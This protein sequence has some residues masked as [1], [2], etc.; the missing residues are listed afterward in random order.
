MF[1]ESPRFPENISRGSSGGPRWSTEIVVSRGGYEQRNARWGNA[2]HEYDVAYGIKDIEHLEALKVHF[3][4]MRGSQHA[5]R[6]KD[7]A[8]YKSVPVEQIPSDADQQIG[9]G[10]VGG[11]TEF[12]LVKYYDL[13]GGNFYIRPINKPVDGTVLVAVAGAPIASPVVDTTTGIVTITPAPAPGEVVTAG[14][15]FDVP[16][17]FAADSLITALEVYNQAATSCNL[18]EVRV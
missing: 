1:L 15:E 16:T 10:D 17:R 3:M 7:W 4:V 5:F 8:D 9:V 14:F 18:L 6:Y 13:G 2:R 12:Q 11:T